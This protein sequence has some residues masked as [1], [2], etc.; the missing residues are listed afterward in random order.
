MTD[1]IVLRLDEVDSDAI[2]LAV[3]DGAARIQF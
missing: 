3:S 2:K 1:P